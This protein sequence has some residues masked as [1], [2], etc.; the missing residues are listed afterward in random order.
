MDFSE[1]INILKGS[2]TISVFKSMFGISAKSIFENSG[3]GVAITTT[4]HAWMHSCGVLKTLIFENTSGKTA[5]GSNAP[6]IFF[7]Y[8]A[9]I[10]NAGEF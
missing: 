5:T 4:S 7:E 3:Q 8:F 1:L 6:T 2:I 10:D 9:I